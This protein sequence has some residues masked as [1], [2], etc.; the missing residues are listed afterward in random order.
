M[1]DPHPH[2][3]HG[4]PHGGS[5]HPGGRPYWKRAHRDWRVWIAAFFILLA[6]FI[7]IA[8]LDL[9]TVPVPSPEPPPAGA[10]AK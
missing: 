4:D 9:R 5:N 8:T 3:P 2:H 7:Y 10:P 6:M 1:N